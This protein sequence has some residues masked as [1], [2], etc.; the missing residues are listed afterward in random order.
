MI[1]KHFTHSYHL[2]DERPWPLTRALG[3]IFL[4]TGFANWFYFKETSLFTI[5]ALLTA[6]RIIQWWRDVS[7]EG[8]YLGFHRRLVELGLR[9]G[10]ALFI[11]SE[12]FFFLSFFW[13]FFHSSLAPVVELGSAWP[14]KGVAPFNP[15]EVPLLNTLILLRSGVTITWAHHALTENKINRSLKSLAITITLGVYFSMLQYEEYVE[16]SFSMSDG[17]FGRTFFIATGFHGIHVLIGSRFL[18]I[19]FIRIIL[20]NFR[21]EHHFGFEA[22]AWYWHFVDVVWLFLFS[23]LYW[24]GAL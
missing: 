24:W 22:A 1:S 8:A 12:I 7:I 19:C 11:I 10:M 23:V 13:A 6:L 3:A 14:P 15:W 16:S 4:T 2:V 17:V 18:I 5:G 20:G 21:W 9:W